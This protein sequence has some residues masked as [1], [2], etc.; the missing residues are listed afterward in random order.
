MQ[1][2]PQKESLQRESPQRESLQTVLNAYN[3]SDSLD[4]AWTIPASWYTDQRIHDLEQREVFGGTWQIVARTDQLSQPGQ[5]VTTNVGGEPIVVMR[6]ADG[7]L[8]AFFNVCRHH[9]AEVMTACTGTASK[10]RCPYHGWTYA[11][12]GTLIGT[13]EFDDV[14]AFEKSDHGLLPIRVET[15]EQFV[16]VNLSSDSVTLRAHL[17]RMNDEVAALNIGNLKFLERRTYELKCNWKVFVDNYLDGGYHVPHI[18]KGL[19]SVLNYTEYKIETRD[20]YCLQSSPL[21]NEGGDPETAAVRGG[22]DAFYYWLYPNFMLN[23]YEGIMDI[24]IAIPLAV[25]RTLVL[26]DFYFAEGDHQSNDAYSDQSIG[27]AEVVQQED[28]DVCESVQRGLNS[29]A[30]KAGRLSVRREAGEQ[31]FHQLLHADLTAATTNGE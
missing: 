25:D 4:R 8:R 12:D 9:A 6:G 5:F 13:P 22:E 29:R 7:Q 3:P 31:L 18:H 21:L 24:N 10:M 2:S 26:F 23:W 27:V 30:Y 11:P 1:E 16:F 15:W 19:A 20:R 28:I 17:G 14:Q